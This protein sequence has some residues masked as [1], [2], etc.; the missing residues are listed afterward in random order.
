MD[1]FIEVFIVASS[2]S[3]T[4]IVGACFVL[5]CRSGILSTSASSCITLEEKIGFM[6]FIINVAR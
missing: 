6:S 3:K 4:P 1:I 2:P 5:A